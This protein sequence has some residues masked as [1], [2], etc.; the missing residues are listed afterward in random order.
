[1]WCPVTTWLTQWQPV[2]RHTTSTKIK[3]QTARQRTCT[4]NKS[5]VG[6][7]VVPA[8]PNGLT[9]RSKAVYLP[10]V[11]DDR[12]RTNAERRRRV[13]ARYCKTADDAKRGASGAPV[14][15]DTHLQARPAPSALQQSGT[16]TGREDAGWHRRLRLI[17]AT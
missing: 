14:Q 9:N 8:P 10:T 17:G 4:A 15:P 3:S 6:T 1:V 13:L 5:F 16:K 12:Q 11:Y 2:R 7:R